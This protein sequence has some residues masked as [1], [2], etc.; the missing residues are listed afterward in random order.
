MGITADI[1]ICELEQFRIAAFNKAVNMFSIAS[2]F[3][4]GRM[5]R[6]AMTLPWFS[7]TAQGSER[8]TQM[9]SGHNLSCLSIAPIFFFLFSS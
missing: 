5:G 9:A 2:C 6:V 4:K 7:T 8:G 3:S 1:I